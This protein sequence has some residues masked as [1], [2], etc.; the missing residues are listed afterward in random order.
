MHFVVL[1]LL[2]EDK[3][4]FYE[5]RQ[6]LMRSKNSTVPPGASAHWL[7]ISM[8][9]FFLSFLQVLS[10]HARTLRVNNSSRVCACTH[11]RTHTHTHTHTHTRSHT[12]THTL[13]HTHTHTPHSLT[14]S[15]VRSLVRSLPLYRAGEAPKRASRT[16]C[17]PRQAWQ[18]AELVLAC[19]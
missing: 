16:R 18:E 11:A 15:R 1:G 12:H 14:H 5:L 17:G 6:L 9:S 8:R 19:S 13:T 10:S 4:T 3:D 2:Q 7:A